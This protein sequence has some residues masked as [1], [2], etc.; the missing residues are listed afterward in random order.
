M[1]AKMKILMVSDD[2]V[3]LSFLPQQLRGEGYQVVI[4]GDT[5]EKI[6]AVLEQERPDFVIADVMMPEF[7]GI[8]MSLRV[9][10]WSQVPI[11]LLTVWGTCENRVRG[12]DLAAESYLTEPFAIDGVV[13]RIDA[14]LQRNGATANL[15]SYAR[16]GSK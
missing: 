1:A 5:D 8:E 11:L 10:Q 13:Q 14:A 12:L 2:S 3:M 16:S 9:R 4:T 15:I 6:K 7:G